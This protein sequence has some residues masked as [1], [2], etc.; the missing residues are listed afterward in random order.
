M[1][2]SARTKAMMKAEIFPGAGQ[3]ANPSRSQNPADDDEVG[4]VDHVNRIRD[5]AERRRAEDK[6]QES[7]R[8]K[9]VAAWPRVLGAES[10]RAAERRATNE[11]SENARERRCA[12]PSIQR[13]ISYGE[14]EGCRGQSSDSDQQRNCSLAHPD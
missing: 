12:N 6:R 14:N 8:G 2:A 4:K 13:P 1:A 7:T 10:N 11:L 3:W 5:L 9:N